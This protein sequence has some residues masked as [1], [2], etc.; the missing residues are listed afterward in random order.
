MGRSSNKNN[1]K[2]KKF[3]KY[4]MQDKPDRFRK[5]HK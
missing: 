4:K 5:Y 2:L 1:N 3:T